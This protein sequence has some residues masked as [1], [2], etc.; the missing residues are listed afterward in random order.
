MLVAC[1]AV[2]GGSGTTVVAASLALSLARRSQGEVT[3]VDIA[4]DAPA[5]LG[6]ADPL[7]PGVADWARASADVPA[8]ALAALRT[9]A[10]PIGLIHRGRGSLGG[11]DAG[12]RLAVALGFGGPTVVDCGLVSAEGSAS[13][14]AVALASGATHS[15]LVMRPCFLSLRAALAAPLR[16]SGVVLVHDQPRALKR[17]D[18]EEVLGVAVRAEV[19]WDPAVARA[20]DA[21]LLATALPT[22]LSKSLRG[23]A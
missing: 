6:V 12:E 21:G 9:P 4:G 10:G 20:V 22:A 19:T 8:A 18:V 16:P 13:E 14:A 23:A 7:G 2:K 11:S 1:W 5:A 3:L 15:L 17:V